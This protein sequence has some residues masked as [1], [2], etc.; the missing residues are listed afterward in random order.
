MSRE[1][2]KKFIL[3]YGFFYCIKEYILNSERRKI[4]EYF[5][6]M[7]GGAGIAVVGNYFGIHFL[8]MM[9]FA[10]LYG[11]LFAYVNERK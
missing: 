3:T 2:C 6:L 9:P 8:F 1:K 7:A 10:F 5:L 11:F 4:M